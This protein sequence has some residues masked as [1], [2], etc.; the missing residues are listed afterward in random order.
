MDPPAAE[1]DEHEDVEGAEPGRLDGE[2]VA[3]DDP[4]RLGPKELGPRRAGPS[5]GG[6]RSGSPE[7]GSDR[8]RADSD[9]ELAEL[10]LDPDAAPARVLP[11][12]SQDERT[13]F[14]I[15]R[16]PAR[17]TGLAVRPFPAYELAVPSEER[18]RRDKEGDPAVTRDRPARRRE[19]DPVDGPELRPARRPLQHPELMAQDE[20][21][22]VLGTVV[23]VRS[24]T[25]DEQT[26]EGADDEVEERPHH[27]IVLGGPI[28]NRGF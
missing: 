27:P 23:P 7:H 10:A 25:P 8:R 2:E 17:A 20:D 5:W 12:K 22:E 15:D 26:D 19:Q 9:A 21:L 3:R 4:V 24:T 18:R 14:G 16:R 13:E 6:T 28:A 11:G 1:L